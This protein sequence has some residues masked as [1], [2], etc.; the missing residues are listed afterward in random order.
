MP[1][2]TN[3]LPIR[4][5]QYSQLPVFELLEAAARGRAGIDRRLLHA[6]VDRPAEAVPDLLRFG[7]GDLEKYPIN[8]EE[9]LIAIFRHLQTPEAAGFFAELLRRYPG[10]MPDDLLDAFRALGAVSVEPLLAAYAELGEEDGAEIPFALASLRIH[11]ARILK[12]LLEHLEY[13]AADGALC[14]GLYGDPAGKPALVTL[15]GELDETNPDLSGL[16]QDVAH[17]LDQI[18]GPFEAEPVPA[19]DFW[20]L[21]PETAHPHFGVLSEEE[22]LAYLDS[23]DASERAS[24]AAAFYNEDLSDRSM[25]RLY[26]AARN[27]EDPNVRAR[28]W[29]ALGGETTDRDVRATMLSRLR[30]AGTPLAEKAGLAVALAFEV[31]EPAIRAAILALYEIPETRAKSLEAMWRTLD[32]EFSEYFPKHLADPDPEIRRQAIWGSGQLGISST[33]D[34]LREYFEDD[35]Y[36]A[37]ALYAYALAVPS[38]VTA[39]GMRSLLDRVDRDAGGLTSPEVELVETALDQRLIMNGRDPIF[40]GSDEDDEARPEPVVAEAKPGRNDPCP[41]GSGKK[42]KKCHGQ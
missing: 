12:V 25:R 4:P 11:D 16:R 22:R 40:H 26:L 30:S 24:A 9:D 3:H 13:D 17:A 14:L 8:L 37:E 6:I 10:E 42:F 7:M 41:C 34:K 27:D 1:T 18:E 5:D 23:P 33:I 19:F 28:C 38:Q 2:K 31:E 29:E 35:D 32:R 20:E 21:F 39:T 15:L 36:R